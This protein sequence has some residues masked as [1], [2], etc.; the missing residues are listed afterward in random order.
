M[1]DG[2]GQKLW[3][4][5]SYT[6]SLAKNLKGH[7]IT[8]KITLII[9]RNNC[10]CRCHSSHAYTCKAVNF[11][12]T[13]HCL[14]ADSIKPEATLSMHMVNKVIETKMFIIFRGRV[15]IQGQ[16]P[17]MI[18]RMLLYQSRFVSSYSVIISR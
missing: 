18:K 4:Q 8:K 12:D 5:H 16:S 10:K 15:G 9:Y 1:P 17:L 11:C 2:S 3:H 13:Y 7:R 6:L 14:A